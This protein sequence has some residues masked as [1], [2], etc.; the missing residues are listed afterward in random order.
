MC[1]VTSGVAAQCPGTQSLTSGLVLLQYVIEAALIKVRCT[2]YHVN[3]ECKALYF[4]V[5]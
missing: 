5:S 1:Y 3:I 4:Q 2:E